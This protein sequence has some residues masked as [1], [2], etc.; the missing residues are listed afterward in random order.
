TPNGGPGLSEVCRHC[1]LHLESDNGKGPRDVAASLAVPTTQRDLPVWPTRRHVHDQI[2]E[3]AVTVTDAM[4]EPPEERAK[5]VAERGSSTE[6]P[7]ERNGRPA[8]DRP[9]VSLLFSGGVFR[10]VFLVGVVNGLNELN[11]TPD[12]IAGSSVGS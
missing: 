7:L 2:E 5:E 8:E 12:V 11:V 1:V 3:P 4:L 6:W 9:T 10:G